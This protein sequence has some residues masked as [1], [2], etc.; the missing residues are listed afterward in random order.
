MRTMGLLIGTVTWLIACDGPTGPERVVIH[1]PAD[2]APGTQLAVDDLSQD[3]SRVLGATPTIDTASRTSCVPHEIHIAVLGHEHDEH[4]ASQA[5]PLAAQSYEIHE[6][7]C[8]D[9]GHLV[10]VRGGSLLAAEWSVYDLLETLGVRYLHPEQTL[11]PAQLRWP[12]L[13]IDTIEQPAIATRMLHLHRTHPIELSAPLGASVADTASYQRR[14]VDWNVRVRHDEVDGFDE[15]VIGAYAYDRGFP[16]EVGLNLVETQQGGRP[17][18]DPS[19]PRPEAVQIAEAI[20]AQMAPVAGMPAVSRFTFLFNPSEFTVADEQ[21]TLDRLTFVTTYVGT[22]W[23]D[24]EIRT[25]NHGTAQSPGPVFG[26]R[27][28][29]L[30]QFA[31]TS[32]GVEVHTLMF[33]DLDRPA[34]VYGNADFHH[35]RD[36]IIAQQATR[37]IT[38][39]PE[40]SWWLTFDLPVPLYLA[41]VSL[42][43]RDHDLKTLAPYLTGDATAKTGVVGHNT[44][45]SG[46]EWGYWMID[47][48]TARMTWDLELGW[49]G[50]LDHVTDTFAS[51]AELRDLL[52]EVGTAQVDSL[53]DPD[54]I[55]MLVGSDDSTETA[56]AAG[57][58]F[59]P[60]PPTPGD[61]LGWDDARVAQFRERSLDR[62]PAL[63]ATYEGW[64]TRAD[65]LLAAQDDAHTTWVAEFADGLRITGLRAA[66]ARAVYVAALELRAAIA[67]RDFAAVATAADHTASARD[68]TEQ[69]R[70]I[71]T[72]RETSYRYPLA[73]SIAGDEVGTSGAQPN[74]TIYPYRYLSRTHRLFY[75]TRPDSQL[76][77]IFGF[78]AVKPNARMIHADQSLDVAV[79]AMGLSELAIAWGDG[80]TSTSLVPHMYVAEGLYAWTL[81]ALQT[82]GAIHHTDQ[83]VVAPRILSFSRG[84]LHITAPMGAGLIEGLLPGFAIALGSDAAGPFLALGQLDATTAEITNGSIQRRDRIGAATTAADLR[85]TLKNLG[86][87]TVFDAVIR[88]D[89]GASSTDRQLT[90]TGKLSTDEIIQLVVDAGGFDL[91]GARDAVASVLGY[92]SDTLPARVSFIATA[93]GSE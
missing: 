93:T 19:D 88:T 80:T 41:P 32:L 84:A 46:Q 17:V 20:D 60:L 18:I 90:I 4:F 23:P 5:T 72:A 75:W 3:L 66:H 83:V 14:W 35:L 68:L 63:A 36:W 59:H 58:T 6:T 82:T 87:I 44:F 45:T 86:P 74:A 56:A 31:P 22:H 76:A 34:P 52:V 51:G 64:A 40:S 38:Y 1:A 8:G 81:D 69:A 28:F 54:L 11:Y 26:V 92:T 67:A 30:P 27:F 16:R 12:E 49:I 65:A 33:Y 70:T 37:R 79:T 50:C 62:L 48:C 61:V 71:V 91:Q 85:V 57:I 10:T 47:Y 7:R 78:D 55:A 43:A 77:A 73:L 25:I 15:S 24:V 9:D 53:R 89:D 2:L 13:P 42:E 29:D 21:V 39:Y